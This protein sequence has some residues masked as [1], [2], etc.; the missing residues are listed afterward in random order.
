MIDVNRIQG[1]VVT[2]GCDS[3]VEDELGWHGHHA[4][5]IQQFPKHL[6]KRERVLPND[7]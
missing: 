7:T 2:E 5:V 6:F 4:L 3:E 1:E